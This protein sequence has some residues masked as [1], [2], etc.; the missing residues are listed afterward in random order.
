MLARRQVSCLGPGVTTG[1]FAVLVSCLVYKL[2]QR[3]ETGRIV[4]KLAS[5][6][7]HTPGR[8]RL[9]PPWREL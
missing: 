4:L 8:T 5:R 6:V 1:L 3:A 7:R 2:S 9:G